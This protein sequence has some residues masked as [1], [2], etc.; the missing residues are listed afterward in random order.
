MYALTVDMQSLLQIR[1]GTDAELRCSY[2]DVIRVDALRIIWFKID[3]HTGSRTSVWHYDKTQNKAFEGLDDKYHAGSV[4]SFIKSHSIIIKQ[5]EVT[6][7]ATYVCEVQYFAADDYD[8]GYASVQVIVLG[9]C[10]CEEGGAGG[11]L[12]V[13]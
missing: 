9:A 12:K 10:G 6:D 3:A 1:A 2:S 5:V 7:Q 11:R 4:S 13:K 8:E